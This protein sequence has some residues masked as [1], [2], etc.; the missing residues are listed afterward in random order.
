[1]RQ[2]PVPSAYQQLSSIRSFEQK[3]PINLEMCGKLLGMEPNHQDNSRAR[4]L[5]VCVEIVYVAARDQ[6]VHGHCSID[7]QDGTLQVAL[8][9]VAAFVRWAL[10]VK[11]NSGRRGG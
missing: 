6:T 8:D 7:L 9:L 10:A 3:L 4:S 2:L 1:M 11:V 5:T